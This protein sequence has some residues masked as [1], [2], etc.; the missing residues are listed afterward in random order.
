[1]DLPLDNQLS[2]G[3][4]GAFD[5]DETYHTENNYEI[6]V[7]NYDD[8]YED[9]DKMFEIGSVRGPKGET[10]PPVSYLYSFLL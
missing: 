9:L 6:G 5:A 4:K 3:Q 2:P 1:M 8:D 7:D 10:G